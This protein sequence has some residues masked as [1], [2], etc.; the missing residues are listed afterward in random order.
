[1]KRRHNI[2]KKV[3]EHKRKARKAQ[4]KK[5]K[6]PPKD[7]GVPNSLP[8]KDLVI[9]EAVRDRAREEERRELVRSAAQDTRQ[10]KRSDAF[11]KNRNLEE[12]AEPLKRCSKDFH[13]VVDASDVVLHVLDARDP[14]GSRSAEVERTVLE[15]NKRLI[16][17]LNKVDLVPRAN[18]EAWL[19]VLREEWPTVAFKACTQRQKSKLSQSR[20][21]VQQ[22]SQRLL[23]SSACVGS[24]LLLQLLANYSRRAGVRTSVTVGVVG[25][26]N[27][28]KSS[29][30]NSLKRSR[31]CPVGPTA[32]LTTSMQ[33]IVL[34]KKIR[35]VDSP[36]VVLEA[37]DS[38][39]AALRNAV[40]LES[41]PDPISVVTELLKRVDA[42]QVQ[43]FYRIP[44]FADSQ[45]LLA[46][47]A[48]RFGKLLKGGLL[49]LEGVAR[50]VLHDWNA[51][52]IKFF[53]VPPEKSRQCHVSAEI[54][55]EMRKEFAF[56]ELL[57]D[58][59][60]ELS[61]VEFVPEEEAMEMARGEA[62]HVTE[63]KIVVE[64]E[65]KDKTKREP[66][67]EREHNDLEGMQMNKAKK[68]VFKKMKKKRRR[69]EKLAN[70]LA[71]ELD[72]NL[73]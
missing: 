11:M 44:A 39:W 22:A 30:I 72:S 36:G 63:T 60:M 69:Q 2:E 70:Q 46:L 12:E 27:V 65:R 35:L 59:R 28:G 5:G 24:Q 29:V 21:S 43:L 40:R 26:P 47:L 8:F 68:A 49:D 31:A 25:F 64:E 15:R 1:M 9:A 6:R 19:K 4:N 16:L 37:V 17:V 33:T 18:L 57:A 67:P 10:E 61:T 3:R 34:D 55:D 13:K 51:G 73:L 62:E 66:K 71:S 54:V 50:K 58:E 53:T 45:E 56:D 42:K 48:K 7:P 23:K 20:Q 52:K 38:T 14:L 41:L 32:G